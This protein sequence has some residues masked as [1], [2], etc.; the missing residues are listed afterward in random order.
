MRKPQ[1]PKRK[2]QKNSPS[3]SVVPQTRRG[4]LSTPF[5]ALRTA[6]S[7]A[8]SGVVNAA[9]YR[10]IGEI[11]RR[12]AIGHGVKAAFG[13]GAIASGA[14]YYAEKKIP[15]WMGAKHYA[16]VSLILGR[17][18]NQEDARRTIEQIEKAKAE[19]NP[20]H[21]YF[22]EDAFAN[23]KNLE[24]NA[25]AWQENQRRI[26][27][28]YQQLLS[29]TKSKEA[30]LQVLRE[31][32]AKFFPSL[33]PFQ[34]EVE[35]HLAINSIKKI[36]LELYAGEELRKSIEYKNYYEEQSVTFNKIR[37]R[38]GNLVE[39]Q[40]WELSRAQRIHEMLVLRDNHIRSNLESGKL[41]SL[42]KKLYPDLKDEKELR[43]LSDLGS[44]HRN[45]YAKFDRKKSGINFDEIVNP[46][47]FKLLDY[48]TF[49]KR[50]N[51]PTN[52]KDARLSALAFYF[53]DIVDHLLSI[54][55]KD[56]AQRGY[57]RG[58]NLSQQEFE[59]LSEES[60]KI[61]NE[62][63]RAV[64]IANFLIGENFLK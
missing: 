48:L 35:L 6:V 58:I 32:A 54:K 44:M 10:P 17:H 5:S 30:A 38:G 49:T 36:P 61:K 24:R 7:R 60:G 62:R 19:G 50:S 63:D 14:G 39:V 29:Q 3:Q 47:S 4:F 20:Y 37:N 22:F 1:R 41:F 26:L 16:S 31:R 52:E 55:R 56:L 57:S 15:Y 12:E 59:Q 25:M 27:A 51:R 11:T 45:V 23:L 46:P 64:F 18:L 2:K 53:D 34:I 43:A 28:E 33:T 42:A 9:T 8:R 40:K 13:L 21:I